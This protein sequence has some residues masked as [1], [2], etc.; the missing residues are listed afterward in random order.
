MYSDTADL[1]EQVYDEMRRSSCFITDL[2]SSWVA[3]LLE[4]M[5]NF[6]AETKSK[7]SVYSCAPVSTNSVSEV[8]SDPKKNGKL[9]K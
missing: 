9:K 4:V 7:T 6:T 3:Y 2:T 5:W 1:S 8:Y